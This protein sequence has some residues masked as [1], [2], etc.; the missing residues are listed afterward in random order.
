MLWFCAGTAGELIKLYPLLR[1]A[2]K[3]GL[4]W[5]FVS[6]GQSAVNFW[7]QW[8]DFQLPRSKAVTLIDTTHDL[9]RSTQALAW[10]LRCVTLRLGTVREKLRQATGA[11]PL[12]T[13]HWVVHGDT[14]STLAGA[15]LGRRLS[16]PIAHVEAGLRSSSLLSPFPEE[17]NRRLVSRLTSRHFGQDQRAVENLRQASGLVLN[18][19]GNTLYDALMAVIEDPA[20]ATADDLPEGRYAVA[21]LHRFE[22]LNSPT[23]W[24]AHCQTLLTAASQ[25][26]TYL[27]LHPPTQAKLEGDPI[28]KKRLESGGVKLLPRQPFT[29]FT[30]LMEGAEF[31]LSDGGSNQEECYYLGKPCLLLRDTTERIE[32]LDG[33]PCVLSKFEAPAIAGFLKDP[34]QF[35]RDP[36]RFD[37][38]PSELILDSLE[39]KP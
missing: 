4:A 8:D 26:P 24:E 28:T 17:I 30:R 27:V 20:F 11:L 3:R 29:R 12:P 25:M 16:V 7:T 5:T 22:N 39:P 1:L 32:G 19:R 10:W 37:R 9:T 14:L 2:E 23:R 6:T 13:D 38:S 31:L 33:G 18:T 35:K 34:A 36:V 15:I 21:N